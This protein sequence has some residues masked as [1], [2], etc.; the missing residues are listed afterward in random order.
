VQADDLP[1]PRVVDAVSDDQALEHYPAA[2]ADLV[3]L[4]SRKR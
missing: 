3:G 4:A 1:P 2:V